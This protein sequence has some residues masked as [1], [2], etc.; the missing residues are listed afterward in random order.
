[1]VVCVGWRASLTNL[2]LRSPLGSLCDF[3]RCPLYGRF[4]G[5]SGHQPSE[6]SARPPALAVGLPVALLGGFEFFALPLFK[7]SSVVLHYATVTLLD[8]G[9]LGRFADD[10]RVRADR[11]QPFKKARALV[12]SLGLKSV[13]E[14]SAY[15]KSGKK[16]DDIPASP[17]QTYLNEGWAGMGDWLG[18]GR[19][20]A[21]RLRE[22]EAR[23]VV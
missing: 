12:R 2:V 23:T 18:T 20:A 17:R 22:S 11:G 8:V 16:P 7:L 4:R 15:C 21:P 1:L 6:L 19:V 14:W 10:E 5:H 3:H 13:A 9:A